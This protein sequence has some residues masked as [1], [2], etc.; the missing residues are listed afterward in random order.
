M[1]TPAIVELRQLRKQKKLNKPFVPELYSL[2]H[3]P[4]YNFKDK[5]EFHNIPG[6]EITYTN[7]YHENQGDFYNRIDI[8]LNNEIR[9]Y[10]SSLIT[11]KLVVVVTGLFSRADQYGTTRIYSRSKPITF[12]RHTRIS[13][14]D[15]INNVTI[16]LL[17]RDDMI[18]SGLSLDYI[19]SVTIII[20]KTST[21]KASSYF[22]TP[23]PILKK[24]AILNIQNKDE[25]CFLY[26][27]AAAD[28]PVKS[29]DHAYRASKYDISVYNTTDIS[30]P[31]KLDDIPKFEKLNSKAINVYTVDCDADKVTFFDKL[32]ISDQPASM[33]RIDLL[34]LN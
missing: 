18:E 21:L 13:I 30:F 4:N 16:D 26:C 27:I 1:N 12:N 29:S 7:I 14:M 23:K 25:R 10:I 20:T 24:Q 8:N 9:E 6:A 22:E 19:E 32:Y 31:M 3:E 28:N 33:K 34:I 5:I 11:F 15:R 17:E 2:F